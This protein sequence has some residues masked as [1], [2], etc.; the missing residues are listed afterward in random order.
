[1]DDE[2]AH[3]HIIVEKGTRQPGCRYSPNPLCSHVRALE[4]HMDIASRKYEFRASNKS[5][6]EKGD[7]NQLQN[8]HSVEKQNLRGDEC[9]VGVFNEDRRTGKYYISTGK[10]YPDD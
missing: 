3:C 9:V 5:E 6:E 10:I 8:G 1:M 4:L 7:Y 2:S